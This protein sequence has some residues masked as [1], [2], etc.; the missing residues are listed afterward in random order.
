MKVLGVDPGLAATGIGLVWGR[1]LTVEGFSYGCIT[2]AAGE[3]T[4]ARLTRIYEG[5]KQVLQEAH[6]DRVVVE[7]IFSLQCQPRS[8]ILL[9]KVC[10]VILLAAGQAGLKTGIM[11]IPVR[12]AKRVLTGNGNAS[13][14]QLERAVR[15]H[16]GNAP[17]ISPAHASDALALALIGLF[18]CG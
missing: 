10:G 9:G 11:E 14:S 4:P 8:G 17:P 12:E 5:L 13:K 6:P 2:T 1:G 15:R 16:L 18:R 3:E 7:D